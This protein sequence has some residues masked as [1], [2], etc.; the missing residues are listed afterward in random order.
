VVVVR[1]VGHLGHQGVKSIVNIPPLA[2]CTVKVP[3]DELAALT[4]SDSQISWSV[5]ADPTLV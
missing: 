1:P 5:A 3:L 4:K 2:H